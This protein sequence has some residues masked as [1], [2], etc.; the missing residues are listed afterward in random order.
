MLK[1]FEIHYLETINYLNDRSTNAFAE[2]F[3][4]KIKHFR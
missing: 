2:S 4:E 3:H 1:T